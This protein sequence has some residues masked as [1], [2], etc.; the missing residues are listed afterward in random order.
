MP[1]HISAEITDV[2]GVDS[3][4]LYFRAGDDP[5]DFVVMTNEAGDTWTAELPLFESGDMVEYYVRATDLPGNESESETNVCAIGAPAWLHLDDGTVETI[6]GSD[7]AWSCGV[8]YDPGFFPLSIQSLEIG[9]DIDSDVEIHVWSVNEDGLPDE[10][11]M[12]PFTAS[13]TGGEYNI[14]ELPA[15][16]QVAEPFVAGFDASFGTGIFF[17]VDGYFFENTTLVNFEGFG[18]AVLS[19]VGFPGNFWIRVLVGCSTG[20]DENPSRP[21]ALELSAY[22][23]P[24]NPSTSVS[25]ILPQAGDVRL[26]VYNLGGQLV[27]R[28]QHGFLPAGNHKVSWNASGRASGVYLAVL[29]QAHERVVSKL[30]LAR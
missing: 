26:A 10:D 15:E 22:P 21:A 12:D 11:L 2:S 25:L 29:E 4:A 6:V 1:I 8:L 28:L 23:N 30:V 3:A 7:E 27:E 16:L 9:F 24:F 5:W 17:D 19:D 18:W 20:V 14:V 13:L